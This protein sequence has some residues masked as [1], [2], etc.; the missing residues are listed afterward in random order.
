MPNG[1]A[2]TADAFWHTLESRRRGGRAARRPRRPPPRRHGPTCRRGRPRRASSC[3]HAELPVDLV[4]E[5]LTAYRALGPDAPSVAVRSS[6]TAEDLPD[7][8]FAGQHESY[9]DVARRGRAGRRR[10]ALLREPLHRPG[11][12]LPGRPRLR[13]LQGGAVG[14]RH[15]HGAQRPRLAPGVMFTLDTESGFRDVVFVDLG[16]RPGRERRPGG[17]RPRRVLRA[18]AD[19]P[20]G[21][22][23]RA[24][25]SAW[26]PR[27][28]R[29][30]SATS[31]PANVPTAEDDQRR[32]SITDDEVLALAGQAH[33]DRGALRPTDGHRVGQGRRRRTA[34][35]RAGPAGDRRLAALCHRS[36][37][38]TRWA[39]TAGCSSRAVP[40][41]TASPREPSGSCTDRLSWRPSAPARSWSPTPPPRTGSR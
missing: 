31:G 36:S 3:T 29:W 27:P 14:R 34:V 35:H 17:R 12:P 19:L 30:C 32:F 15:A 7:A 4:D 41:A 8:S 24:P 37:T 18:Q 33:A 5:I 10:P 16:V 11:D 9:L 38:A 23:G 28:R 2:I 39:A 13:P 21:P 1:F 22:P 25:A 20:P 26:A 6:A 40:S